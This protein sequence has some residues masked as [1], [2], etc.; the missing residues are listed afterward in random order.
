[1]CTGYLR[2]WPWPS[3]VFALQAAPIPVHGSACKEP[4]YHALAERIVAEIDSGRLLGVLALPAAV[5]GN[6]NDRGDLA[7]VKRYFA[8]APVSVIVFGT[9]CFVNLQGCCAACFRLMLLSLGCAATLRLC[10]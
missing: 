6:C 1:M 7:T 9:A 10:G 8:A 4:A 5:V 2:T 3:L